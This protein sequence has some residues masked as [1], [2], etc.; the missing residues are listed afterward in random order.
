MPLK[1]GRLIFIHLQCW[2]VLPLLCRSA[3]AAN[4]KFRVFREQDFYAPL[5]LNGKK[6]STSEHWRFIKISLANKKKPGTNT[7]R[8]SQIS[9]EKAFFMVKFYQNPIVDLSSTPSPSPKAG[10]PEANGS[11]FPKQALETD[12]AGEGGG[13]CRNCCPWA[14]ESW[15]CKN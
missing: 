4:V 14:L 8:M 11:D 6:V 2:E 1:N 15:E 10:H 13:F 7:W 3:P 12:T 5:A 9:Q